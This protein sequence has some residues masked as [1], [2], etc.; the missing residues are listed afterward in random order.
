M[1]ARSVTSPP[2]TVALPPLPPPAAASI[3]AS[4][5]DDVEIAIPIVFVQRCDEDAGGIGP[6]AC[7][8]CT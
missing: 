7:I 6:L 8:G 2:S 5:D 1:K 3:E 4:L